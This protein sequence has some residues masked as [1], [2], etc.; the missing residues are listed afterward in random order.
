M[1][2]KQNTSGNNAKREPYIIP[3]VTHPAEVVKNS[4]TKASENIL[5]ADEPQS[6][7]AEQVQGVG[8]EITDGEDG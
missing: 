5:P 8:S 3:Q 6:Q 1:N 4:N 7:N 2:D